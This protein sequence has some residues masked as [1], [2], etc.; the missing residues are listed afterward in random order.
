MAEHKMPRGGH[1]PLVVGV[2]GAAGSGKSTVTRLLATLGAQTADADAMVRWAYHEPGLRAAIARRFGDGML[3]ADGAVNRAA[4]AQAVFAHPRALADL[5]MMVHPAVL[6]Q[7]A[8]L[9]EA[10]R[11]DADRA[12]MLALEIPLLY[13]VGADRMVDRVLVVSASPEILKE[14]LEARGW[15]AER[16]AG[17]DA[18]QMP[19]SEKI[20]RASD[21]VDASGD[22]TQTAERVTQWWE[23]LFNG[24]PVTGDGSAR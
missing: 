19:L 2:T 14:R 22:V 9:I 17:V 4:L 7:L 11:A 13:E 23:D 5:E 24:A 8:D 15:D 21:A 20:A 16:I 10:Y 18:A 3:N 6:N 12:P 1:K